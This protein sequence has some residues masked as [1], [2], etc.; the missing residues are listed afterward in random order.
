MYLPIIFTIFQKISEIRG[1]MSLAGHHSIHQIWASAHLL[2]I[3]IYSIR[4]ISSIFDDNTWSKNFQ[5]TKLFYIFWKV[6]TTNTLSLNS[7]VG[8]AYI[9]IRLENG[10]ILKEKHG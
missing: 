2:G 1:A 9:I 10:Y 4:K 7:W 6:W 8:Q 5:N 3:L